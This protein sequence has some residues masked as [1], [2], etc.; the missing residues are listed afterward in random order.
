MK[1]K[2]YGGE[3]WK[4]CGRCKRGRDVGDVRGRDVRDVRDV[5]EE[6]VM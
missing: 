2:R 6:D 4:G 1:G 5:R 3:V